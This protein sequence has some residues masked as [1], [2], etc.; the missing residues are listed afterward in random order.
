LS[1]G[2]A[3]RDHESSRLVL[4]STK[5]LLVVIEGALLARMVA[6]YEGATF[7]NRLSINLLYLP[8]DL[9]LFFN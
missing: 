6:A 8:E 3:I 9:A 1:T 2:L 7:I 4:F 5:L